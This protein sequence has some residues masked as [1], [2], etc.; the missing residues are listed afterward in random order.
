MEPNV[1]TGAQPGVSN[2]A[3]WSAMLESSAREVFDL[4]MGAKVELV[5]ESEVLGRTDMT[6]MVGLAGQLC[7]VL[8]VRC[9][10][11]TAAKVATS[12]LGNAVKPTEDQNIR[13]ALGEMVNMVAGNF[14]SKIPGLS[15]SCLLSV[16][17]IIVGSDYH[18]HSLAS[19]D[20]LAVCITFE[21]EPLSFILD[22]HN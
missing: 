18:L 15:D 19:G 6:G 12:L 5:D 10:R 9:T 22:V 20:R 14:K 7:G 8:S 4:M 17:T 21:G 3:E 13:D 2:R 1:E 11:V 16:P